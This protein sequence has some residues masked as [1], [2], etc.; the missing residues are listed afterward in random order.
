[1]FSLSTRWRAQNSQTVICLTSPLHS[2]GILHGQQKGRGYVVMFFLN[3]NKKKKKSIF[4]FSLVV[5]YIIVRGYSQA[6][7]GTLPPACPTLGTWVSIGPRSL[8]VWGSGEEMKEK[9]HSGEGTDALACTCVLHM[10]A[11]GFS[12]PALG[13]M[14]LAISLSGQVG[15][16]MVGRG[17]PDLFAPTDSTAGCIPSPQCSLGPSPNSIFHTS[18]FRHKRKSSSCL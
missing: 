7:P 10:G 1:M 3:N 12:R 15:E 5:G 11:L 2:T 16:G 4:N 6:L 8:G 9:R 13:V 18:L 14:S 17:G